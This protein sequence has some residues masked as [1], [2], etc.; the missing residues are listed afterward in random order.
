MTDYFAKTQSKLCD[1]PSNRLLART[2]IGG[3]VDVHRRESD[4]SKEF[5]I[6]YTPTA[7]YEGSDAIPRREQGCMPNIK[8]GGNIATAAL[9]EIIANGSPRKWQ[10][11]EMVPDH[12]S[13][14]SSHGEMVLTPPSS[15]KPAQKRVKSLTRRKQCCTKQARYRDKQRITHAQLKVDVLQKHQEVEELKRKRQDILLSVK[16]NL[17]PWLIVAKVFRIVENTLRFPWCL[18][19]EG[20]MLNHTETQTGME[21]LQ[22]AFAFHVSIG[23]LRG[24]HI[25]MEKLRHHSV[26]FGDPR[27]HLHRIQVMAPGVMTAAGRFTA[28]VTDLTLRH[29]FPQLR[30]HVNEDKYISLRK[31]LQGHR[32][33]CNFSVDFFF[34][35]ESGRVVRLEAKVDLIT[36]L[37]HTLGN[38]QDFNQLTLAII[39]LLHCQ[40]VIDRMDAVEKRLATE[41]KK[42]DGPVGGADLREYQTQ[43][44]LQLRAIRD[45]MQKEG[46]S[47]EQL[48]KERDEARNERDVLQK[49]VDKLNYRVHHLKQHVPVPTA[50]DM[51]L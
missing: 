16:N 14:S 47:V 17:S 46:S 23:E 6:Q 19:S 37:L 39:V 33:S 5:Q 43:L 45:T 11:G 1:A 24:F 13:P 10:H 12:F 35:E 4:P 15:L 29:V 28:S 41:A 32:F 2:H 36:A 40:N 18:E 48:R 27:F 44:L 51:Q 3:R 34:D 42:L 50:V 38:L 7:N 9:S 30:K 49:Q 22:S 8:N 21:F 31:R 25:M 20:D 26:T